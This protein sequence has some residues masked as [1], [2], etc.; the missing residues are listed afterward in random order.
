M[1]QN[2]TEQVK[3]FLDNDFIVRKCLFKNIVSLRALSRHI[4]GRVGLKDSNLDAVISA[5]RRYKKSEKEQSDAKLKKIFPRIKVTTR[6]NIVD[7]QVQKTRK[8][9]E[10]I[11]RLNSIIDV[12]KG[13]IIRVIQAEQSITII[14]DDKNLEKFNEIFSKKDCV[15][16]TKNLVEVNLQ[17]TE[18]AQN[19]KGIVAIVSAGLNA[20]GINI[21]EIMSSAPELLLM[22]RKEDLLKVLNVVDKLQE[23]V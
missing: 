4:I 21:A 18:E 11:S 19:V 22:V 12:E 17:F 10:S 1:A 5:I 13:E 14:I 15:S 8:N 2:I 16:T 3:S 20:E 9:L 6:S 7:L 23:L